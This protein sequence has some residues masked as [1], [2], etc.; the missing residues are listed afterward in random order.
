MHKKVEQVML[1]Q[2]KERQTKGDNI[3][4]KGGKMGEGKMQDRGANRGN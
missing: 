3:T 1:M 4:D 2:H